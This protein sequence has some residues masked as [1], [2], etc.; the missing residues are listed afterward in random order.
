[1]CPDPALLCPHPYVRAKGPVN[2][3]LHG[4]QRTSTPRHTRTVPKLLHQCLSC[5][6]TCLRQLRFALL[7]PHFLPSEVLRLDCPKGTERPSGRLS[8]QLWG[9]GAPWNPE[10][11]APACTLSTGPPVS[12]GHCHPTIVVPDARPSRKHRRHRTPWH[13]GMGFLASHRTTVVREQ[14]RP[15]VMF[16]QRHQFATQDI[17]PTR[18][19]SCPGQ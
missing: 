2:P 12:R 10:S 13:R 7:T 17:P 14:V 6:I 18:F 16:P 3:E 11:P 4:A 9:L 8:G 1:M 15:Q 5:S 19:F